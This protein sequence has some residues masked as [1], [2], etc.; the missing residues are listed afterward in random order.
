VANPDDEKYMQAAIELAMRGRGGVE[1]N[2]MVGCV[3]V[4]DGQIIGRGYHQRFGSAH[5]EPNA[6]ASCEQSPAG[7]TAYVTLEPCCHT[8]KQ[9]PP[10][11]PKLIEAKLARVVVGCL[12]PNPKVS[13]RGIQLLRDAGISVD[14]G[15][16]GDACRQLIAPFLAKIKFG[17]PYVTLKWAETADG[18]VA[19]TGGQRIAISGPIANRAV[20]QL[21][22]RCD[23][24]LVGINTV[25]NDD[26]LLTVRDVPTGRNPL[27][28][29]LDSKLR[30]PLTSRLVHTAR[31]QPV[32]VYTSD[33]GVPAANKLRERDVELAEL[34]LR[35][36]G[37]DLPALLK[38]LCNRGC[39]HLLVEPGPKLAWNLMYANLVDRIWRI[40]SPIEL[41]D[42]LAPTTGLMPGYFQDVGQARLG[43]DILAEF[44][45]SNSETFVAPC[46]SADFHLLSQATFTD[47]PG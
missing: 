6:L 44:L 37:L 45:N 18:K 17:R 20:H 9:T 43:P 42:V 40:Q 13:G 12:D 22:S 4:K 11:V 46:P 26:P 32:L 47:H 14:V 35:K 1:P 36:H 30:I 15:V 31:E 10:C 38:D 19:G 29:V 39:M 34:P 2:P 8:D 3:I 27:R 24:I 28:I 41:R 7:A 23:A 33:S 21:R 5:A 16:C 25:L